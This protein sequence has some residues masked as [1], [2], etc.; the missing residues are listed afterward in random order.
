MSETVL[1]DF[2]IPRALRRVLAPMVRIVLTDEVE[3]LGLTEAVIDHVE[4]SMRSIPFHL[5]TGLIAGLTSFELGAAAFPS[6]FGR[7]FSRLPAAKQA[8]YFKSWWQS[9]LFLMR[10]FVK[11]VKGL[12]AMGF[13]EQRVVL[14][15]LEYHPEQWIAEVAARRLRDYADDIARQ[16]QMVVE[17]DPLVPASTLTKKVRHEQAA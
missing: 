12:I 14:D 7:T 17:R 5:R 6:S 8:A 4:L 10:Q 9:P 15:R 16:D 2:R 3:K 11:S 1:A 13:Y